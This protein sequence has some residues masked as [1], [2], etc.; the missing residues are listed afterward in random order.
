MRIGEWPQMHDADS[1]HERALTGVER[2]PTLFGTR[3]PSWL[4]HYKG[5]IQK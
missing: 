5:G 3:T 2:A 4:R 1:G